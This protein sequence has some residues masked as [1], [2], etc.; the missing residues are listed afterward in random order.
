[1]LSLSSVTSYNFE[2]IHSSY[3]FIIIEYM[4]LT[5]MMPMSDIKNIANVG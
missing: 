3:F 4:K 2:K 1:L 5:E